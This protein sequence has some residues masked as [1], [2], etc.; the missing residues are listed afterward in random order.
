M[1]IEISVENKEYERIKEN[2]LLAEAFG[3]FPTDNPDQ[4]TGLDENIDIETPT[5]TG[6]IRLIVINDYDCKRLECNIIGNVEIIPAALEKLTKMSTNIN[7]PNS[8]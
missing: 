1:K 2:G 8:Q 7:A 4:F 6:S 5:G 3:L